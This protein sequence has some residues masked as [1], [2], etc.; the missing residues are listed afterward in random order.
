M[1]ST[2]DQLIH[3]DDF[4]DAMKLETFFL[5][6]HQLSLIAK[7]KGMV[8]CIMTQFEN[9]FFSKWSVLKNFRTTFQPR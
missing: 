6:N 2:I 3:D 5:D 8:V 1:G 7:K 4:R 9:S